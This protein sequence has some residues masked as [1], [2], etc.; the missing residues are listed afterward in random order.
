MN[1]LK[2]LVTTT[3]FQ[4]T[5]GKHHDLLAEQNWDLSFLRGPLKEEEIIAVI[6]QFDAVI[7]GDDEYTQ[8]VLE[9]GVSG[10]LKILSKYGVGL[11]K[12]DLEAAKKL[13][14]RVTN[15]PGINQNSVA[16]H[17]F[18][19]LLSFEK[20]IHTQYNSVQQYSWKRQIGHEVFGKTLGIIG[21]GAI[22]KEVARIAQAFKQRVLVYDPF[23]GE[24]IVT[25]Y[26]N[27]EKV[28]DLTTL[29]N[30]SNYITLHTPL[31]PETKHLINQDAIN[32][33]LTKKSVI[34]NTARAG[35]VEIEAI[36]N[37][38]E[39]NKIAGYLC[40]VLDQE[41]ISKS[42]KLVG[43]N[44]VIITPH[45]GSRTYENVVNQGTMAIKNILKCI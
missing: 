17:V 9:K 14:V 4:D 16:E 29:F 35:L 40:D 15:C 23:V 45:V 12:I 1:K 13:G 21:F 11:D 43:L 3:S 27:V 32:N 44:N 24:N 41:P 8:K 22:G 10:K 39:N 18:A 31:T 34:I 30:E 38:I 42:E 37:G 7:C 20:N 5:P 6:D 19:L 36:I 25:S 33:H 28:E 2:A 26:V